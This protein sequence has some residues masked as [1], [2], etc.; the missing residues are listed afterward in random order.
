[1]PSEVPLVLIWAI[2]GLAIMAVG[3]VL[4]VGAR[5]RPQLLKTGLRLRRIGS[6]LIVAGVVIG[7]ASLFVARGQALVVLP[8]IAVLGILAVRL[9]RSEQAA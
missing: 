7:L 4:A 8:L 3:A 9:L 2:P 5:V 6:L 1:M